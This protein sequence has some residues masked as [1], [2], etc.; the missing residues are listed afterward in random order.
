M[1]CINPL[2]AKHD[3]NCFQIHFI[4][5]S[6]HCYWEQNQGLM[7]CLNTSSFHPLEV[8]GRDIET[9]LQVGE[10]LN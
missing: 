9:Q 7:Q 2:G 4:S 1:L 6:N 5:R 10:T 3:Y 8:V